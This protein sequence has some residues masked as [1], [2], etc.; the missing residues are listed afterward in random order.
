MLTSHR[1]SAPGGA[2]E[3]MSRGIHQQINL[4]QPMFRQQRQIFSAVMMI[5]TSAAMLVV[6][7]A[8]YVFGLWQVR[9]LEAEATLLVDSE[10]TKTAQLAGLDPSTGIQRRADVESELEQVNAQLLQQQRVMNMLEE[11]PLGTTEGFSA[12]LQALARSHDPRLSLHKISING[13]RSAIELVGHSLHADAIPAYL[14]ALGREEAL[15]GQRFDEFRIDKSDGDGVEFRVS[16]RAA[17]DV[18]AAQVAVR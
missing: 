3:L 16:S 6:L 13:A 10:L 15:A 11:R 8:I 17:I 18:A 5:Q 7:M 1:G 12:Y 4:Y 2:G 9:A 14:T